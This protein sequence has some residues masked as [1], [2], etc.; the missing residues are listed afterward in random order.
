MK[1][2]QKKKKGNSP[3]HTFVS[4]KG[5]F[6]CCSKES[7]ILEWSVPQ[8]YISIKP[9]H[10]L[11]DSGKYNILCPTK[12]RNKFYEKCKVRINKS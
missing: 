7:K 12:Q 8:L 9:H 6:Q 10:T 11:D 4:R 3:Q 5:T 1:V 2:K